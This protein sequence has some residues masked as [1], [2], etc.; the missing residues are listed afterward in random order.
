MVKSTWRKKRKK[1]EKERKRKKADWGWSRP[2]VFSGIGPETQLSSRY[3]FFSSF[4]SASLNFS[5]SFLM[6]DVWSFRDASLY[7]LFPFS[8][9]ASNLVRGWET[10]HSWCECSHWS[11]VRSAL[12]LFNS[13]SLKSEN[14]E[15]RLIFTNETFTEWV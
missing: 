8:S 7:Q 11:V 6:T 1:R 14:N 4:H 10:R 3:S 2:T 5:L 9:L 13:Y 12:C 15:W